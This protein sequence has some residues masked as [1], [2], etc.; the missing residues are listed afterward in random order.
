MINPT[1]Y[2]SRIT[3]TWCPGCGGFGIWGAIKMAFAKQNLSKD[4]VCL[5]YDVG[6]SSNAADFF[7]VYGVHGLHGRTISTAIGI[8]LTNPDFPV[9]AIGGD[10]GVYGEG[11]EHF[12]EAIRG[13]F[14]I[15]A[16][17]HNNGL[18][19][20]TTGQRSPISYK[21]MKTKSTP[22]GNI[23]EAFKPLQTAII[24][25]GGFIA[26]GF[27]GDI[28]GVADLIYEAMQY[29]GFALVDILQPCP[30][31]NKEMNFAWYKERVYKL[32]DNEGLPVREALKV[33][34]EAPDRLVTGV[35][36]RANRETY[37]DQIS[38]LQTPLVK[39]S[40]DNINITAL[41][42]EFK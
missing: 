2:Q 41:L 16:I 33:L 40:I 42:K 7:S 14:N 29:K 13:N 11:V 24:H 20:L 28:P 31:F 38:Y 35:L 34:D 5:V 26:R 12:I 1:E 10:G 21:G 22:Y 9:L 17:V 23:E 18:Y 37:I 19:S 30:S 36:Y 3:P 25:N 27:A 15:T 8:H 39:Q 6:C 4:D 32:P